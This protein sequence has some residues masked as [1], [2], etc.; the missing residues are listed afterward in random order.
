MVRYRLNPVN[1]QARKKGGQNPGWER[2]TRSAGQKIK[3][4]QLFKV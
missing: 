3:K 2:L 4:R 1:T